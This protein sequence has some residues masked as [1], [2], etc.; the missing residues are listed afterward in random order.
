MK[1]NQ[2]EIDSYGEEMPRFRLGIWGGLAALILFLLWAHH[3]EIDQITR[4]SGQVIPSSRSQIIQAPDGG[5][6]QAL[7]VREGDQ[8]ERGQLLARLDDTRAEAAYRESRARV[9]A[10]S[11]TVARL[12]AEIFG[13]APR[14]GPETEGFDDF[15]RNQTSLLEKRRAAFNEE[16][17][18]I[19]RLRSLAQRELQMTEPLLALGDVSLA[20]VLRLQ[21]QVA[22]LDGQ[23][24][25]RRNKYLQDLQAELTAAE[26][27]LA[28]ARETL[29]QRR[30]LLS[31]TLLHAP[32]NG[33]VTN[34][35]VTT[36]GGVLRPGDELMHI[37]PV[38][39]VLVVEARVTP[40]DVAYL[41]PGQFVSVK[42]DAFDFTIYGGLDG[43]LT[44][45][46]GDTLSDDLRYGEQPYYRVQ[47]VTR[48]PRFARRPNED[49]V[50]QPG[51][52]ATIE[53]RTGQNTVLNY[54]LKPVIKT[55]S[56]SLG[57]R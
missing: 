20:D 14:F 9:G 25:N 38:E 39:D 13:G 40:S 3:A 28:G 31:N 42:I 50:L 11:A 26:E 44:Y 32:T 35:R 5:V 47:V 22:E 45:I 55:F 2:S 4:G 46:S 49:I 43:E 57:E 6:L 41:R 21:R 52:T 19:E 29:I 30:E 27:E 34:V 12:Q 51:M 1:A 48:E 33:K 15:R 24:S 36:L 23:L 10:L 16:L 8:V 53:V 17:R 54:L 37:V 56:E 7:L 18:A